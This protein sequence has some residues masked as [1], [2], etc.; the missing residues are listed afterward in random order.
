MERKR[1]LSRSESFARHDREE[2]GLVERRER[3]LLEWLLSKEEV[4]ASMFRPTSTLKVRL[5]ERSCRSTR[6][7]TWQP[8]GC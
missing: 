3:F 6:A 1:T 4:S 7:T 2:S 8:K 5:L